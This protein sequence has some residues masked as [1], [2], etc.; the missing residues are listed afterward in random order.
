MSEIVQARSWA[1]VTEWAS[2]NEL[3]I[4]FLLALGSSSF[5][6]CARRMSEYF[7]RISVSIFLG[8]MS[9]PAVRRCG[10]STESRW[11]NFLAPRCTRLS[12]L[13]EFRC[14]LGQKHTESGHPA[15]RKIIQLLEIFTIV[16]VSDIC[17]Q[18][19]SD[20]LDLRPQTVLLSFGTVAKSFLMPD[21]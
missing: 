4:R 18:T 16:S 2:L 14:P 6:T 15:F 19:W 20:I 7:G 3:P 12:T 21:N 10:S 17:L 9:S 1:S 13:A 5:P 8:W 11:W